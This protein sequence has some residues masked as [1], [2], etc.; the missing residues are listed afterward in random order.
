MLKFFRH[1]HGSR[2]ALQLYSSVL[3]VLWAVNSVSLGIYVAFYLYISSDCRGAKPMALLTY[4]SPQWSPR[5][6]L[7]TAAACQ[8]GY[9]VA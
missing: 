9:A 6:A 3:V 4:A 7:L 5:P 8:H 2:I 1:L